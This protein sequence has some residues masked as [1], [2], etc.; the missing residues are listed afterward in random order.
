VKIFAGQILHSIATSQGFAIKHRPHGA[1]LVGDDGKILTTGDLGDLKRQSPDAVVQDFADRLIL[2]GFVDTHIHF[3]QMDMIGCMEPALL[4]WLDKHVFAEEP[5]FRGRQ[6]ELVASAHAFADELS[7]NGTTVACVYSSSDYEA[8]DVLMEVFAQRGLRGIIGKTSMDQ[9]GPATLRVDMKRDLR[10]QEQLIQRWHGHDGRLFVALTPRYAPACSPALMRE[11][12]AL[13]RQV[14]DTYI[15]THYAENK[16]GLK[17]VQQM[18]PLEVDYL[19]VYEAM[20]LI[21]PRTILAHGIHAAEDARRRLAQAGAIISH[22]PTSNLFLGSGLFA[23]G[24]MRQ[25][26]VAVTLGTDVGAG[27]SFSLWQTMGEA[28]KVSALQGAPVLAEELFHT[29]TLGA[30]TALNLSNVGSLAPGFE[31]DFQVI[32]PRR[33]PILERRLRHCTTPADI[34]AALIHLCDDRSV[35]GVWVRGKQV[36]GG[37]PTI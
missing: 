24:D 11:L 10:E 26:Q 19:A 12:A 31:A 29:A 27:T 13:H 8:T 36:Y 28:Y 3:P 15:Q 21:G 9:Q 37:D 14:P 30:A 5:R 35:D 18:F 7:G 32:D 4:P 33:R 34:L 17:W 20:Q 25:D 16:D 1:I 23:W 22:C 2:P 6:P